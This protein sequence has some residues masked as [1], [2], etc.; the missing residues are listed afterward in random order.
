MSTQESSD[1]QETMSLAEHDSIR[2]EEWLEELRAKARLI[3]PDDGT[4]ARCNSHY[5]CKFGRLLIR[6]IGKS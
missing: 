3:L 5:S 1:D 4:W 2:K 6:E